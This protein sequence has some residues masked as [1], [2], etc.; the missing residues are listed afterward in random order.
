MY[1]GGPTA[2]AGSP[3]LYI[4]GKFS[5]K[6]DLYKTLG[7]EDAEGDIIGGEYV[8]GTYAFYKYIYGTGSPEE[9]PDN[10]TLWDGD[11]TNLPALN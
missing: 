2:N 4:G 10:C 9:K 5:T 7:K 6:L 11:L 3:K 8:A 1:I